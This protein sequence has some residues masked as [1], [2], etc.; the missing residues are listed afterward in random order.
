MT[1]TFESPNAYDSDVSA[2]L[3]HPSLI[4][5]T[6]H[7]GDYDNRKGYNVG[8]RLH[9]NGSTHSFSARIERK[10]TADIIS[11]IQV[12]YHSHCLEEQDNS[13]AVNSQSWDSV[14]I[15]PA[16]QDVSDLPSVIGRSEA[17][18]FSTNLSYSAYL[19][20]DVANQVLRDLYLDINIAS[21]DGMPLTLNV[22]GPYN[23]TVAF[24]ENALGGWT[25]AV[26]GVLDISP[27]LLYSSGADV[28]T[29]SATV[30]RTNL[31]NT[32]IDG[33]IHLDMVNPESTYY[34]G[35]WDGNYGSGVTIEPVATAR[36]TPW[37]TLTG[38]IA[39]NVTGINH[40]FYQ[41]FKGTANSVYDFELT[42]ADNVCTRTS[43]GYSIDTFNLDGWRKT[44]YSRQDPLTEGCR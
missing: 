21:T 3:E 32:L 38:Y 9:W 23:G 11:S 34:S 14:S 4:L 15:S 35:M 28:A 19:D 16:G 40:G 18:Y 6:G 36:I 37:L 30:A 7:T 29:A 2:W 44:L 12:R 17:G 41:A 31:T 25:Y 39:V 24:S 10:T 1:I 43:Y 26:P 5:Q 13:T 22:T 27:S 33:H 8:S 42:G 20:Y